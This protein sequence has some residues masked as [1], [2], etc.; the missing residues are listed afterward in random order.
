MHNQLSRDKEKHN[1]KMPHMISG[2]SVAD[3]VRLSVSESKI[4][5]SSFVD[6]DVK[7]NLDSNITRAKQFLSIIGKLSGQLFIFKHKLQ[8]FYGSLD[9]VQDNPGEPVPE[10]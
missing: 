10:R 5:C 9:F 8:P 3:G 7:I 1:S 4:D 6:T 2:W